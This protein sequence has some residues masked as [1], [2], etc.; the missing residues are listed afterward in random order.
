MS[1]AQNTRAPWAGVPQAR[2]EIMRANRRRDTVPERAIRSLLHAQ[3]ERFR[4]DYPIRLSGSRPIRADVAFPRRLVAVFVDGCFWHGCPQHGTSPSTNA[5]YWK[6][7]IEE[8]RLRD[9][10]ITRQLS[11]AG[12]SV[13][14]IWEHEEPSEAVETIVAKVKAHKTQS[15]GVP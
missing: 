3:G 2:R 8:N 9:A 5:D 11:R 12:W 1:R 4:V 15:D 7:K 13:V 6:R 10:R 14:R